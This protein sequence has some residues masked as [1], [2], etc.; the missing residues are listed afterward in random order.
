MEKRIRQKHVTVFVGWHKKAYS[1]II[2]NDDYIVNLETYKTSGYK[3]GEGN[4]ESNSQG[5]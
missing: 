3:S 2:K 1:S 4:E 5:F